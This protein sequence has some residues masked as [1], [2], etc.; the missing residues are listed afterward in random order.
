MASKVASK[1]IGGMFAVLGV[2][3]CIAALLPA[4]MLMWHTWNGDA[5]DIMMA[6]I[7]EGGSTWSLSTGQFLGACGVVLLIGLGLIGI[8][9]QFF[10]R[11]PQRD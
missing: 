1:I 11:T 9:V 6:G 5:P 4:I 3:L 2:L 10:F 7:G 8:S